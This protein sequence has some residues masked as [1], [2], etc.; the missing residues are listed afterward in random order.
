M[1]HRDIRRRET[2]KGKW[3]S[4]THTSLEKQRS[5][6]KA[7]PLLTK[8]LYGPEIWQGEMSDIQMGSQ[9]LGCG[10]FKLHD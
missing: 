3:P 8:A 4:S 5:S 6:E 10:A 1:Q 2:G 9:Y 7:G